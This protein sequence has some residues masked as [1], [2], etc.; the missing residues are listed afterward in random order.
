[1]FGRRAE[2]RERLLKVIE[3]F[4]QKGAISPD[5]AMTIEELGLPSKFKD[6]MKGRLG[7]LGIFVEVDGKYYLSEE[8]LKEVKEQR[9]R[10][11]FRSWLRHTASV[12]KGFLRYCVL[13]LLKEN[14]MSGSEIIEEVEKQTDGRWKPS[15]GSVYPL[16]A[17]LQDNG[18]TKE[19]PKEEGGIKR[20]MLT[21]KGEN[22]FEEQTKFG[23]RLQKKLEFLAP[24]LFGGFWFSPHPEELREIR[25]PVR[26][27]A[28][29]L[30]DLRMALKE[31][32]TG[33]AVKEVAKILNENAEKIEEISKRIKG[34]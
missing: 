19:L 6:L 8:R 4:R 31:N 26:R 9:S 25:E 21:E 29:A 5:K 1:M 24:L 7:R 11:R 14:P 17:W 33:Q 16:L 3:K 23:E 18:Y 20:Y 28:T 12:P 34:G 32:L 30:L 27:F 2:I 13:K 22:L 15:P 10:R